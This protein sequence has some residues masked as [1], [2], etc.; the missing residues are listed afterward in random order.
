MTYKSIADTL[1]QPGPGTEAFYKACDEAAA[2]LRRLDVAQGS[3]D[4][5]M[6]LVENFASCL[7]QE[8]IDEGLGKV[9]N[10]AYGVEVEAKI[11]TAVEALAL[12]ASKPT[13]APAEALPHAYL[14]AKLAMV[15]PLFQECRDA[16]PAITETRRTLHGISKTLADRMD[17]A[18]TFSLADW[19]ALPPAPK[20]PT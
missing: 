20:E 11:R 17:V 8:G 19:E 7:R 15:M 16:L 5:V 10:P 9:P 12:G 1:Q 18:G 3:V 2:I 4:G 14:L 13:G 6:E